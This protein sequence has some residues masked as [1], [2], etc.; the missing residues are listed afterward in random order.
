MDGDV[1]GSIGGCRVMGR[2][3]WW[4]FGKKSQG[5]CSEVVQRV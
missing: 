1:G 3:E 2:Q 5:C 4:W